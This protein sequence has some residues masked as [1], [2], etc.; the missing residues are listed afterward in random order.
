MNA[1]AQNFDFQ[2]SLGSGKTLYFKILSPT[3]VGLTYPNYASNNYYS[4]YAKPHGILDI[5]ATVTH[6]G[7]TYT[8]TTITLNTF[9]QCD[10]LTSVTIPATVSSIGDYAF[11]GCSELGSL[12]LGTGVA[13]IGQY[14]FYGCITLPS[15]TI[16][17]QMGSIGQH[18]FNGCTL[19][20]T[21]NFQADSC[22]AFPA[23][24]A[25][26]NAYI[27]S[28]NNTVFGN[29]PIAYVNFGP[30]VKY[31]PANLFIN[32]T[33]IDTIGIPNSVRSIGKYA[34][35]G[36]KI[37]HITWGT[38]L[39]TIDNGAF[40]DNALHQLTLPSSLK[41]IGITAFRGNSIISELTIPAGIEE[42]CYGA[43]SWWTALTNVNFNAD[44]CINPSTG[45]RGDWFEA[46]PYFSTLTIGPDVKNIPFSAFAETNLVNLIIPNSVTRIE[47]RAFGS[48]SNLLGVI[49]GNGVRDI[50]DAAFSSCSS[51]SSIQMG[52]SVERI[53]NSAFQS[54]TSLA[55]ITIP[56]LQSLGENAFYGCTNLQ[57]I[58]L[59]EGLD[60]IKYSAFENCQSLSGIDFPSTL[61]YLGYGVFQRCSSLVSLTF[62]PAVT[63]IGERLIENCPAL[64]DIYFNADSCLLIS[65]VHGY[66]R[67]SALQSNSLAQI[68]IGNNVRYLP[69]YAF[70]GCPGVT[71]LVLPASLTSIGSNAFD[72]MDNLVEIRSLA[73][74][75]PSSSSQYLINS[76]QFAIPVYVP[77]TAIQD[78][79]NA[80]GWSR[81]TNYQLLSGSHTMHV[82]SS[83]A[84]RGTVE[85]LTSPCETGQATIQ[86]VP[87]GHFRFV[88]WNDGN[89]ENPRSVTLTHDTAFIASFEPDTF[90]VSSTATPSGLGTVIGAGTY[91]RGDT[92]TLYAFP[93]GGLI[94]S[95]WPDGQVSNPLS[96][97][98]DADTLIIATFSLPP[99]DT[100]YIHDTTYIDNLLHDTA[101][102]TLVDT[103]VMM[104]TDTLYLTDT[105]H[106]T[107]TLY[108]DRIVHDTIY[109]TDTVYVGVSEVETLHYSL[110]LQG[111]QI[112]VE[113]AE[114][115]PVALYDA[116][117]RLLATR[118]DTYQP[119]RFEAP[120]AGTYLVRVGNGAA[121]RVVV[122]R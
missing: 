73:P 23:S 93:T 18:A 96:F 103:L 47:R 102:I 40:F 82:S 109:V 97:A 69:P 44:S 38:G 9:Y 35:G 122:V 28:V 87:D 88:A 51:L 5:P 33:N 70:Y 105:V 80:T 21:I 90:I 63:Y 67:Y 121:R 52:T 89:T 62:P 112:V 1:F 15:L 77:C 110:Y 50:G 41:Y 2:H 117:G 13:S 91:Y 118:H 79:Q 95:H 84:G 53:G 60:T 114:G 24:F 64:T 72:G 68:H 81:F 65:N 6:N 71:H 37:K 120:A 19:L 8:V 85:Y 30:H 26:N 14:A 10:S 113:G 92:A 76:G 56:A 119:V 98:V 25:T 34:F 32:R 78:Y 111:G 54:C 99:V 29:S 4:G 42:I 61:R 12:D 22:R 66:T 107:D 106:I 17:R 57:N 58:S 59:P 101:Y 104:H 43:F 7:T 115:Q 31:I 36:C 100:T 3:T 39:D 46:C 74:T 108:I 83:D 27:Y 48:C 86:A 45:S 55:S 49:I 75:P 11:Y 116:V 94:F 20:R 16:P